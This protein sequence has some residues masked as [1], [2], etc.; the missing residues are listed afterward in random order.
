MTYLLHSTKH[1]VIDSSSLG[2]RRQEAAACKPGISKEPESTSLHHTL[3]RKNT[4]RK[5]TVTNMFPQGPH[6]GTPNLQKKTPRQTKITLY[7]T[8]STKYAKRHQ[9]GSQTGPQKRPKSINKWDLTQKVKYRI[10]LLFTTLEAHSAPQKQET[11]TK[12]HTKHSTKK[13]PTK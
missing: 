4:E 3:I 8:V 2:A 10:R 11:N 9:K 7:P 13:T 5:R 12:M 6:K 1:R